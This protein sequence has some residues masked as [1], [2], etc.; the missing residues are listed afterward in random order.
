LKRVKRRYLAVQLECESLP[1]ERE[2]MDTVWAAVTKLYGEVGASLTGLALIN[3][4]SEHKIFVIRSS[5]VSLPVVRAS[6]ATVT[7]VSGKVAS[8][9]VLAVSG[10]LKALFSNVA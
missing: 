6:L 3:F 9:H 1:S 5:L 7:G 10:T 4:D 8:M 2:F